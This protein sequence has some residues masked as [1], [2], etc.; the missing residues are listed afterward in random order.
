MIRF[1]RNP[2]FLFSLL[3]FAGIFAYIPTRAVASSGIEV[4]VEIIKADQKS[5]VV[6]QKLEELAKELGSVLNY[7]GFRL[8]KETRLRLGRGEKGEV[9]LS[10]GR[11]LKLNFQEFKDKQARLVVTIIESE[12]EIFRTTLLLIN[13]GKVLIG[14]P[15]YKSGVLLLRIGARF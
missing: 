13:E 1:G 12:K 8:V 5:T 3:I 11:L 10:P 2:G 4:Y 15:P 6:D 14:G 9:T 7:T